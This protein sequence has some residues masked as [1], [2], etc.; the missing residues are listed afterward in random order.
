MNSR[1]LVSLGSVLP[2]SR[3]MADKRNGN[4]GLRILHQ[5]K[6][7]YVKYENI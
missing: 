3:K 4:S 6:N 2:V 5:K 1:I 7:R